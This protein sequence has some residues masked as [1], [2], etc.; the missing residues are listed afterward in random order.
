MS[1]WT[2]GMIANGLILPLLGSEAG[3]APANPFAGTVYQSVA[4]VIVFLLLFSLLVKYAWGPIL[5]GLQERENRIKAV[6]EEAEAS[7]TKA[8]QTLGQY[9][10]KLAEAR[11]EAMRII[12]QGRSDAEQV[13]GQIKT[14]A[15][16]EI[17]N[18]RQRWQSEIHA[19]KEQA[20][21]D[22]YAQAASLSTQIAGRILHRTMNEG[23]HRAL[24][25][26]SLAELNRT[27]RH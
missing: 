2:S 15:E 21:S 24:V 3:A 4:A 18:L 26:E 9:E 17:V 22:L 25:E 13:A 1:A 6:L 7:A 19:A 11:A 10:V 5:K 8:A 14:Q 20:I 23:D 27:R 16:Q 12:A